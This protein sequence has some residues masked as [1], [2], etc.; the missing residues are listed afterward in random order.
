[1]SIWKMRL[2]R[3]VN[4]SYLHDGLEVPRTGDFPGNVTINEVKKYF[5]NLGNNLK[6]ASDTETTLQQYIGQEFNI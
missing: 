4:I 3:V 5:T 6:T 2:D 1:M